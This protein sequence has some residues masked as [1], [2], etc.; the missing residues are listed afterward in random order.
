MSLAQHVHKM[1]NR[2][3]IGIAKNRFIDEDTQ[4]E[5]ARHRYLR[6]RQYLCENPSITESVID[7]MVAG[8]AWSCKLILC[9][10]GHLDN[11]QDDI[12]TLYNKIPSTMKQPWRIM[13]CFLKPYWRTTQGRETAWINTPSDVI[14]QIYNDKYS[15][16]S[17]RHSKH[18]SWYL[19]N[20]MTVLINHPNTSDSVLLSI[21][22]KSELPKHASLALLKVSERRRDANI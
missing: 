11:R 3:L 21:S 9:G 6:A 17:L 19:E 12:R 2:E 10:N 5:I 15:G 18:A 8:K 13:N 1:S 22:Q 7:E 16:L 4:L 20:A 14:D